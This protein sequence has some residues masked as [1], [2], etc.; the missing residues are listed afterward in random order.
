M[1]DR[2]AARVEFTLQLSQQ[3]D[4]GGQ[5]ITGRASTIDQSAVD[6]LQVWRCDGSGNN[7]ASHQGITVHGEGLDLGTTSAYPTI[8]Q[9]G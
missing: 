2:P 3:A 4:T 1:L 7:V 9:C 6:G 8:Q 5:D